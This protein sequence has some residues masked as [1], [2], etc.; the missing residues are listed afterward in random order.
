MRVL[1]LHPKNKRSYVIA[2]AYTVES[3]RRQ[4]YAK[5][6]LAVARVMFKNVHH[7]EFLTESGKEFAKYNDTCVSLQRNYK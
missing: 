4:G 3:L 5:Q 6:L 1:W 2:E 7:S